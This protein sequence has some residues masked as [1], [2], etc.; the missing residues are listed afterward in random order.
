MFAFV[1]AVMLL[2]GRHAWRLPRLLDRF[3]PD[4]DIEG[5][6]IRAENAPGGTVP[7][8]PA[9]AAVAPAAATHR[10]GD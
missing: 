10:P 6:N 4:L 3:L 1:P 9:A 2:L 7:P 5:K 8:E